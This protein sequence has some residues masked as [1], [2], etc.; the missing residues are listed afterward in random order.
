MTWTLWTNVI[1]YW[2]NIFNTALKNS[3]GKLSA[4]FRKWSPKD[5]NGGINRNLKY[6]LKQNKLPIFI[7]KFIYP[8]NSEGVLEEEDKTIIPFRKFPF[9]FRYEMKSV[10]LTV[11]KHNQAAQEF[12]INKLK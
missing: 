2:N 6:P 11:F 10:M 1:N 8:L 3:F 9:T 7:K 5:V 4:I 12:F